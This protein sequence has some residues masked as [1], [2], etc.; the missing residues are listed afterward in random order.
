MSL[1]G[2]RIKKVEDFLRK[3]LAEM[4]RM[5]IKDPRVGAVTITNIAV[6]PDLRV[7]KIG[8]VSLGEMTESQSE[9]E[10]EWLDGI[11]SASGFLHRALKSR[12]Q[13][14]RVP[15]LRFYQDKIFSNQLFNEEIAV[16]EMPEE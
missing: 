7:A 14:K 13:M 12:M 4:I 1:Q 5:E 9:T 10:P 16:A 8:L 6:S 3:E 11:Q 15:S 2:S